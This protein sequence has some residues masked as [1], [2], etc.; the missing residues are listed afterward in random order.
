MAVFTDKVRVTTNVITYQFK[1][2]RL[3]YSYLGT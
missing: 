3:D 2:L 1:L